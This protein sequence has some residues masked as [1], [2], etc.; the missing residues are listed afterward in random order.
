LIDPTQDTSSEPEPQ[1]FDSD[2]EVE[3]IPPASM[4]MDTSLSLVDPSLVSSLMDFDK[5]R[6]SMVVMDCVVCGDRASGRHYGAISCEGCKGFFKRSIRKQL[7]YSCR[8]NK[9]CEVTKHHRNRCQYCRLQ[10]CLQMGMRSDFQHER[11]PISNNQSIKREMDESTGTGPTSP[12]SLFGASDAA[13][14]FN[15]FMV[16]DSNSYPDDEGSIESAGDND[17]SD[18]NVVA[19]AIETISHVIKADVEEDR[20]ATLFDSIHSENVI[21]DTCVQFNLV[22]PGPPPSNGIL[23][24]QYVCETASRLLFFSIHWARSLPAFQALKSDMQAVVAKSVWS[25]LFT[26]G[27]VQCQSTIPVAN[28]LNA[29][30]MHLQANCNTS[31]LASIAENVSKLRVIIR[32]ALSCN[33]DDFEFAALK[34]LAIFSPERLAFFGT[35]V[36]AATSEL[37]TLILD[38]LQTQVSLSGDELE[39]SGERRLNKI[40]LLLPQLRALNSAAMEE[41]FF[42]NLLGSTQID[43]VIP[44]ILK[45]DSD[46]TLVETQ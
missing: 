25:E 20:F 23:N 5:N 26:I 19:R 31:R 15:R 29:L 14:V 13:N 6:N 28:V 46:F 35:G 18:R 41:L 33:L 40:L 39:E 7:G 45:M 17:T 36:T 43:S 24:V 22:S 44:Y 37:H 38:K 10:K 3:I 27:L 1:K 32:N 34:A 30:L 2:S 21:P 42:T 11:K 4:R 16:Y 9:A 12:S 8:G